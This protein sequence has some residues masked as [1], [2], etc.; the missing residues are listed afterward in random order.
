MKRLLPG[1]AVL[2]GAAILFVAAMIWVR[3]HPQ[4]PEDP[5]ERARMMVYEKLGMDL[6]VVATTGSGLEVKAVDAGS[7]AEAL[8][9]QVGDRIVAVGDRSV[10]HVVSFTEQLDQY[11]SQRLPVPVLVNR[12]G[13]YHSILMGRRLAGDEPGRGGGGGR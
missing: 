8:G 13:V 9:F 11:F 6:A 7:S 12:S 10:W 1:W 4:E 3:A 5:L 2:L